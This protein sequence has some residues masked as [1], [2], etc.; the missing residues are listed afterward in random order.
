LCSSEGLTNYI[1]FIIPDE[2]FAALN[3]LDKNARYNYPFRWGVDIFGELGAAEAERRA[4]EH[5]AKQRAA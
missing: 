2:E 3:K 1:D 4:E 5:A